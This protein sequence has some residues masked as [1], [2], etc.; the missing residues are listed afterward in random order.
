MYLIVSLSGLI[1]LRIKTPT[2]LLL[3]SIG[4]LI[5]LQKKEQIKII[6]NRPE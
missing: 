1:F 6:K 3:A 2:A 4:R 5:K